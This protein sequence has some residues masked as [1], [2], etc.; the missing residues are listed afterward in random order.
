M[1]CSLL[2]EIAAVLPYFCYPAVRFY[3]Q[4]N[5]VFVCCVTLAISSGFSQR[6]DYDLV[7]LSFIRHFAGYH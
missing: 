6:V 1:E 4:D 5:N 2:L 7:E 3:F